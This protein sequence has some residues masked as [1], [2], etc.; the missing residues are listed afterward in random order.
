MYLLIVLHLK[1]YNGGSVACHAGWL[2][3]D[4]QLIKFIVI[5]TTHTSVM[6]KKVLEHLVCKALN[7]LTSLYVK[8]SLHLRCGTCIKDGLIIY[9]VVPL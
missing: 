4:S 5:I 2:L 7:T 8:Q 1:L 9:T 6:I 3:L